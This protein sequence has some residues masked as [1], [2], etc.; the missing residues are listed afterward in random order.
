MERFT[1]GGGALQGEQLTRAPQLNVQL[2]GSGFSAPYKMSLGAEPGC[3]S[4]P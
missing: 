2:S 3:F 4:L 1:G